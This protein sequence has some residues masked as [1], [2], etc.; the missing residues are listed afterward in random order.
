MKK[1]LLFLF[2]T[3]LL[4][5][6][7]HTFIDIYPT[8]STDKP[9]QV[10]FKWKL[11]EMTSSMLI[12][13]LD[14]DMDG[15]IDKKENEF[16]EDEYFSIL[17]PYSYYTFLFINSKE[18]KLPAPQNFQASIENHQLCYSFDIKFN[19]KF[20]NVYFEFGDSDFYSAMILKEK[21]VSSKGVKFKVTGVDK[22]FY[23]GYRLE[24]K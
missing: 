17:E 24:F 11:D 12:M 6:H 2:N 9:N 18:V 14:Q 20:Q 15:K 19:E 4:F 16:I 22:D 8:F 21:F 23:Y 13:E 1:L 7:P 3:I 10:H 5:A